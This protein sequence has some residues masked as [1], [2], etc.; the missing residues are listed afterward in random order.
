MAGSILE[1]ILTDLLTRDTTISAKATSASAAPPRKNLSKGEWRL[2]ELIQVSFELS[3]LPSDRAESIDQILRDYR[4]FIHPV[5]E[6]RAKH[7]C[8]EAEALLSKGALDSVCN[9]LEQ[10]SANRTQPPAPPSTATQ[11]NPRRLDGESVR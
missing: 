2:H 7:P 3:L 6:T 10:I 5:K 11:L 9:H 4:N 8:T 1:A